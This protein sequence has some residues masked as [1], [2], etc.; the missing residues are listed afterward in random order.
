MTN[1]QVISRVTQVATFVVVI[2]RAAAAAEPSAEDVEFFEK[3]VRPI[4][5]ES[6]Q[7]CHGE[8][9]QEGGLRLDSL[10]TVLNG[11]D[12]GPAIEPG[13]PGDSLL[14]EAVGYAGD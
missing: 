11:G 12:S 8:K 10:A 14:I 4:L 1:A 3:Q 13:K 5:V 2:A 6:C 9:K 7:K